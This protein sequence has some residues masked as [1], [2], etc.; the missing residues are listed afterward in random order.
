MTVWSGGPGRPG[1][2]EPMG[3]HREHRRRGHGTAVAVAAYRP[4][5]FRPCPDVRDLWRPA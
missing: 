5:G 1:L 3:V 4:A 2:L